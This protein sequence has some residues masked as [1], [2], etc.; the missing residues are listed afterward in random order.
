[1]ADAPATSATATAT[2]TAVRL[3]SG[4]RAVTWSGRPVSRLE[5]GPTRSGRSAGAGAN[6]PVSVSPTEAFPTEVS[7]ARVTAQSSRNSLAFR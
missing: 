7:P 5:S 3:P 2:A 4:R 1:V 6:W